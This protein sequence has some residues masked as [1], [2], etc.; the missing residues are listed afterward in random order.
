MHVVVIGAGIIGLTTAQALLEAGHAVTLVDRADQA[1]QGTSAQNGG[2]L[3]YAYVAPL[4]SPGTLRALP[5]L[6]LD[7]DSPLR[8]GAGAALREWSWCLAFLQACRPSVVE[9]TTR[10]LLDLSERSRG[11]LERWLRNVDPQAID[12]ARNGKLVLSRSTASW[13]AALRQVELQAPHGP[14][15][16][17]LSPGQ[18]LELEPALAGER[19]S[20]SG[21]IYTPS[22]QVAD[23]RKVCDLLLRQL[24]EHPRFDVHWKAEAM[25]WEAAAGRVR[26]LRAEVGG[27]VLRLQADAFVVAA[28]VGS[29]ALVAPLG[30]RLPIIPL[31]GYSIELAGEHLRR[32][33]GLSIT[34]LSLKTVFAPLGDGPGRRLRV[35][36]IVELVGQD[37]RLDPR[38]V[39][40]LVDAAAQAVGL[41]GRRP[42]LAEIRPWTGF[43]PAT[44]TGVPIIGPA[45]GYGNLYIN[46]G[47]GTL[48]FTHAF[49][50]ADLIAGFV[51]G[52]PGLARAPATV[53]LRA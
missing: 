20:L 38:R 40:Q 44:P 28:G 16:Q 26:A 47:Q 45:E 1:A 53:A 8:I 2:Q 42:P 13:R 48:G 14:A 52:Q 35:A 51:S 10:T 22:E 5:Q 11:R 4:A 49:A 9:R 34:D 32:M 18:C 3:S 30:L 41:R 25:H 21:G 29:P 23:C 6:L 12:F 43:R 27:Q 24:V 46:A 7:P 33:P 17:V 19:E 50:S 15:Q 37:A 39:R 31:K 36:G